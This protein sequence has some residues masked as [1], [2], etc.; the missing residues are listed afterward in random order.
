MNSCILMAQI[1]R[2]PELR[3][4]Q[5][6]QTPLAQMLVEFPSMKPEDPPSTIK[7]VGWGNLATEI[8]DNY[9]V[10]DR[11]ILE[12]RLT[13]NT[14]DRPEGFKEKRAEFTISRIYRLGTDQ[15]TS[16]GT[17][18]SNVISM[19]SY[20]NTPAK[21]ELKAVP[22]T[23]RDISPDPIPETPYVAPVE[24]DDRNLDDIPF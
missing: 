22:T 23:S 20:N 6:N 4:T 1:I 17:N 16:P 12:G 13:M 7:A 5:E 15:I 19:E 21:P 24:S 10:G 11:I 14:F 9:S 8:H 2:N 3:Y 18:P